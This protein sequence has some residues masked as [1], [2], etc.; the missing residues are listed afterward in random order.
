MLFTLASKHFK[1]KMNKLK[2]L[3]FLD[4]DYFFTIVLYLDYN[5]NL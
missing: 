5:K 3:Y 4:V 1:Q 2:I